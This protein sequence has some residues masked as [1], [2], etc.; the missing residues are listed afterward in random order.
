MA[1]AHLVLLV[2]SLPL[3]VLDI[4]ANLAEQLPAAVMGL[5]SLRELHAGMNRIDVHT[6]SLSKLEQLEVMVLASNK[7]VEV[8]PSLWT[9]TAL[10][11]L[12]LGHNNLSE[13]PPVVSQLTQLTVR[14]GFQVRGVPCRT[15]CVTDC[16][17]LVCGLS[18]T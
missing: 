2:I 5:T 15:G 17:F 4:S 18:F 9:V 1:C 12:D 7:L 6:H 13:L 16:H 11:R 8:H 10:K 14:R 3:Q